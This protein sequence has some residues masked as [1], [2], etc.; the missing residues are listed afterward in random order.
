MDLWVECMQAFAKRCGLAV[1]DLVAAIGDLTL[2]VA[3]IDLVVI[4]DGEVAAAAAGQ[5][6]RGRAAQAARTDDGDAGVLEP[7]LAFEVDFG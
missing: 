7:G 1:A 6:E 4:D 5:I 3:E 2:Q